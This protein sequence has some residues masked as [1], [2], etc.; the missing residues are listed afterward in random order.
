VDLLLLADLVIPSVQQ[1]LG[2]PLLLL[3]LAD[4][5]IPSVQQALGNPLLLLLVADLVIPSVPL[6]PVDLFHLVA[7][8]LRQFR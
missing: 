5:V 3:L 4:L 2:N 1:A 8:A 7:L 6:A